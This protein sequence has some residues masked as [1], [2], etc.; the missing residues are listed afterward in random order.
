PNEQTPRFFCPSATTHEAQSPQRLST[1][2]AYRRARPTKPP[3]PT[4]Q[5]EMISRLF[6]WG[7]SVGRS[8][9]LLE[10]ERRGKQ[11]E[12]TDRCPPARRRWR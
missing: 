1:S 6:P 7:R 8:E 4:C 10:S 9:E 5:R 11:E 12:A 3:G 2:P